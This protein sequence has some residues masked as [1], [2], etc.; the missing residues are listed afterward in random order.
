MTNVP[1]AIQT[2]Q[3]VQ[4]WTMDKET[5]EKTPGKLVK[6]SIPAPERTR[7]EPRATP[8]RS[9]GHAGTLAHAGPLA[10]TESFRRHHDIDSSDRSRVLNDDH[11]RVL[12]A[13]GGRM[14]DNSFF[15]LAI[16]PRDLELES[17]LVTSVRETMDLV[18]LSFGPRKTIERLVRVLPGPDHHSSQVAEIPDQISA[19]RCTEE[20]HPVLHIDSPD[21]RNLD[22][23]CL[24]LVDHTLVP[25]IVPPPIGARLVGLK[26]NPDDS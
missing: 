21:G 5:G 13:S 24:E 6:T 11:S 25:L 3:M 18:R 10:S 8:P 16:F 14:P 7:P 9:G 12:P 4:P 17:H 2:W 15:H 23:G 19:D 26:L 1:D 20:E 22:G